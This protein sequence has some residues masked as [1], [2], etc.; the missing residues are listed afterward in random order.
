MGWDGQEK[1]SGAVGVRARK[2]PKGRERTAAQRASG[3][4]PTGPDSTAA[5]WSPP[6]PYPIYPR[7]RAPALDGAQP[8]GCAD[9]L[10]QGVEGWGVGMPEGGAGAERRGRGGGRGA[11]PLVAWAGCHCNTPLRIIR[12]PRGSSSGSAVVPDKGRRSR[13]GP[14]PDP[15][16]SMAASAISSGDMSFTS[17]GS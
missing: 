2:C 4:A 17:A 5:G 6:T 8:E 1:A 10:V 7:E 14:D 13:P 11:T 15:D 3:A 16:H 12:I 9:R